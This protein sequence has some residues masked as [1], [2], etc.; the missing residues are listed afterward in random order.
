M[1]MMTREAKITWAVILLIG[2]VAN[3]LSHLS[4]LLA[5]GGF[6]VV[7]AILLSYVESMSPWHILHPRT[8]KPEWWHW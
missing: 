5:A 2:L 4:N 3:V 8:P 7:M 1:K 6:I